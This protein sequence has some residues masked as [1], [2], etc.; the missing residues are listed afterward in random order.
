MHT[1][2]T[3]KRFYFYKILPDRV[4]IHNQDQMFGDDDDSELREI[5]T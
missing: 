3:V 1:R 4:N 5:M 2:T